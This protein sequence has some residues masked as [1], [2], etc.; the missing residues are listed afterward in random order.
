MPLTRTAALDCPSPAR[1]MALRFFTER[2]I[3][4]SLFSELFALT[5]SRRFAMIVSSNHDAGLMT[6][7][8]MPRA[9]NE[10]DG[11]YCK[12]LTLTATPTDFDTDFVAAISQYRSK[13][14]PLLEQANEAAAAIDKT[15]QSAKSANAAKAS[16]K[17]APKN[18]VTTSANQAAANAVEDKAKAYR[19]ASAGGSDQ[20]DEPAND[21]MKNRQPELF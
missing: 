21:W 6:I 13:L 18:A 4:M 20:E 16:G 15:A 17:S 8:V 11:Q 19:E 14:K 12:D 2:D 3:T 7:S 10:G 9:L 5:K 1:K